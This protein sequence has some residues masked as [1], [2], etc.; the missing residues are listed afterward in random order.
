LLK[1]GIGTQT[2]HL[3]LT[4]WESNFVGVTKIW[5]WNF[6]RWETLMVDFVLLKNPH[7]HV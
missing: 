1:T 2:K 3:L 7:T 4:V 6:V 5:L